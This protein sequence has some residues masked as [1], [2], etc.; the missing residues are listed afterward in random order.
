MTIPRGGLVLASSS[1]RRAELL[2]M[3]GI[4]HRVDPPSVPE[5][6]LPHETP[7][8]HVERLAR[9]KGASVSRR[10]PGSLVVAGD[11][12][13]ILDGKVLAKPADPDDACRMLESLAGRTHVVASGVA[14]ARDGEILASGV[15]ST[16]V[17]FRPLTPEAVQAYV[18]TGEPMDKAGAYGIQGLGAALVTRIEGDFFAVM[19]LPIPLLVRLL[20]RV[21]HPY[22]FPDPVWRP[23]GGEPEGEVGAGAVTG[24]DPSDGGAVA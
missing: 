9:E 5:E 2:R 17:T 15:E 14:L 11:T 3:L 1:P 7:V 8:A 20:E 10:N 12:T 18:A 24:G 23:K 22:R 13:V 16:R 19:G 4:P 21:G 6:L